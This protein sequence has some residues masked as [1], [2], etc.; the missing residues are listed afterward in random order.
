MTFYEQNTEML[1][2]EQCIYIANIINTTSSIAEV[3]SKFL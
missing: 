1:V 3:S 2:S